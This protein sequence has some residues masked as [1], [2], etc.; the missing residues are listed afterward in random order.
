MFH[1]LLF[2]RR[3]QYA[4]MLKFIKQLKYKHDDTVNIHIHMHKD[5]YIH[6]FYIIREKKTIT[7]SWNRSDGWHDVDPAYRS[8]ASFSAE[9]ATATAVVSVGSH[10]PPELMVRCTE[11]RI[12]VQ[13]GFSEEGQGM[14]M[15][16][17]DTLTWCFGGLTT[18]SSSVIGLTL[19]LGPTQFWSSPILIPLIFTFYCFSIVFIFFFNIVI[20]L[21][22][23]F[24][25][26]SKNKYFIKFTLIKK[27]IECM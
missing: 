9:A 14:C 20:L 13:E 19:L 26:L 8:A 23:H 15:I 17:F 21:K 5:K 22:C 4:F 6:V 1:F 12:L 24:F 10:S 27:K 25:S 2:S 7:R 16:L 18:W 11:S 3:K